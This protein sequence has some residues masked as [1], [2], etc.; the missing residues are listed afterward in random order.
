MPEDELHIG[1]FD[2]NPFN[3]SGTSFI[4]DRT[5]VMG[6]SGS[7]K[8]YLIGVICEE[9]CK[10]NL[11][12]VIIDPEGEYKSLKQKFEVVWACNDPDADVQLNIQICQ[13]L[14]E[15]TISKNLKLVLDTSESSDEFNI[16]TE[17][18]KQL[19][20]IES[21]VRTPMLVII[22]EADR[23]A[24]QSKGDSIQEI[25]EI[26]RR[27]RKRGIGLVIATQRPAMVDKNVLSQ[28]GNQFIG[29][30]RTENDLNAVSLFF[31]SK[32]SLNLIPD[33]EGG[34]FYAMGN[35]AP[36]AQK[37][38][39][40]QRETAHGGGTPGKEKKST[41]LDELNLKIKAIDS[42]KEPESKT[43]LIE[44]VFMIYQDGR[45]INHQTRRLK[46]EID[47]DVLSGMFTA[48]QTFIKDSFNRG[49]HNDNLERLDYGDN[50]ILLEYGNN[51]YIAMSARDIDEED[52][53]NQIKLACLEIS[54]AFAEK[55]DDWIGEYSD[56]YGVEKYINKLLAGDYKR[57]D[58]SMLEVRKLQAPKKPAQPAARPKVKVEEKF[59]EESNTQTVI[60]LEEI[61][62]IEKKEPRR[63]SMKVDHFVWYPLHGKGYQDK[64]VAISGDFNPGLFTNVFKQE[65][66]PLILSYSEADY[67]GFM[68]FNKP[69][70]SHIL[71]SYIYHKVV[72]EFGRRGVIHHSAIIEKKAL[73]KGEITILEVEAAMKKFDE[74]YPMPK[75]DIPALELPVHDKP[76][77]EYEGMIH[78]YISKA[79]V[80]T[81]ATRM[82]SSKESKTAFRCQGA[83]KDKRKSIAIYLTELLT[84]KCGIPISFCTERPITTEYYEFF[85]LAVT[86][87]AVAPEANAESWAVINWD[88]SDPGMKRLGGKDAAYKAI[89]E[90][91]GGM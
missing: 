63:D 65:F 44:D 49:F 19:Y 76:K 62:P 82:L 64:P 59:T 6:M 50:T 48:V 89:D 74:E 40:R 70:M 45:L 54:D 2:N 81:L 35:L 28:C 14:A 56:F 72:D 17:F 87:R 7:G 22:E 31:R 36:A 68:L 25:H 55:L 52:M 57:D 73:M 38:K 77:F 90:A 33:L 53:K 51:F 41:G 20:E 39:V 34:N 26:S 23:F 71:F 42:K 43:P 1:E 29:R 61:E 58:Y 67:R 75:G 60:P 18:L 3:I 16:V 85:N 79:A 12:F 88:V 27:G 83:G 4:T 69:T 86:E 47:Q 37:I 15:L 13:K 91:F 11:P 9:L 46:P 24:P 8:S 84:F 10:A 66:A 78:K 5:A 80:E 30:L 21:R 32:E